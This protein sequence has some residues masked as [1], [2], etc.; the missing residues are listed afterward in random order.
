MLELTFKT[1]SIGTNSQEIVFKI[2]PR[3]NMVR[4][5]FD[6]IYFEILATEFQKMV[7][8]LDIVMKD[9]NVVED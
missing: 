4:C 5:K 6:S 7:R 2:V 1:Q 3:M 8:L 9:V